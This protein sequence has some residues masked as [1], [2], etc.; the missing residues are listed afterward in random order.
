MRRCAGLH[1]W[2]IALIFLSRVPVSALVLAADDTELPSLDELRNGT[3]QLESRIQ[4]LSVKLLSIEKCYPQDS[5]GNRG[6]RAI[7]DDELVD[8]TDNIVANW[9]VDSAGRSW[10]KETVRRISTTPGE[11]RSEGQS[12]LQ[13]VFDGEH[14]ILK[15]HFPGDPGLF[16]IPRKIKLAEDRTLVIAY[17]WNEVIYG[18]SPLTFT[19]HHAIQGND[20]P[21]SIPISQFLATKDAVVI[22]REMWEDAIALLVEVPDAKSIRN[23]KYKEQ[24]WICPARDYATVKRRTYVRDLDDPTWQV[25]RELEL[26]ALNQFQPK[27]WLPS[28]IKFQIYGAANAQS[29]E[30]KQVFKSK[31]IRCT[32]WKLN[33]Q[34]DANSFQVERVIEDKKF[35][36]GL[37]Q[38]FNI[39]K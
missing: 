11:L 24:F 26:I 17:A 15:F 16:G 20:V 3:E 35:R 29:R 18:I 2:A 27:I 5:T 19:V 9:E 10:H 12:H 32:E 4:N 14:C 13:S 34:L 30:L 22:G 23:R 7:P 21:R 33:R 37:L 38:S 31:V 25:E 28:Q 36:D 8:Q 6:R 39:S 1:F